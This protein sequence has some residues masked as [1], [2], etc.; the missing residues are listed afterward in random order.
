MHAAFPFSDDLFDFIISSDCVEHS[1]DPKKS[2]LE[3]C[4]VCRPRGYICITTPN[5]LWYVM[6]L[7][8]QWLEARKVSGIE[9]W[10]FPYQAKKIFKNG[11]MSNVIF[12]GCHLLPF[13]L[14]F[15]RP[16]LKKTDRL[17]RLLYPL[18]INF[19]IIAQKT[20]RRQ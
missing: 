20:A 4:R 10:I 14:K 11:G 19:G 5:K 9:N 16:Y 3:M 7:V 2:I 13:Q 18:M 15:L 17:G 1:A 6:L 12:G 8:T